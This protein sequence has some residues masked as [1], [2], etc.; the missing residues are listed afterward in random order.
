MS[1]GTSTKVVKLS[2][3]VAFKMSSISSFLRRTLSNWVYE[4][5]KWAPSVVKIAYKVQTN[6]HTHTKPFFVVSHFLPC[7]SSQDVLVDSAGAKTHFP[8]F[9]FKGTPGLRRGFV[10]QLR[11][12]KFNVL[13]T[14]Y[15]Y[16]IKD[17]QILA[18]VKDMKTLS[19]L[20]NV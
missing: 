2:F 3:Y 19:F 6:T 17:K 8:L 4:L 20:W 13:L 12:G 18:K 7:L 15:E 1:L 11:S 5:D 16:I 14:T 10:P 9:R